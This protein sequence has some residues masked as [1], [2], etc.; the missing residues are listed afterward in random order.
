MRD[1]FRGS[2][3][4]GDERRL[5]DWEDPEELPLTLRGRR[6]KEQVPRGV[7]DGV[8]VPS[9]TLVLEPQLNL[10]LC[11]RERVEVAEIGFGIGADVGLDGAEFPLRNRFPARILYS[12]VLS[13]VR[14]YLWVIASFSV[15][16]TDLEKK[17]GP[18]DCQAILPLLR[19][20]GSSNLYIK[21]ERPW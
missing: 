8:G 21:N 7:V 10:F 12:H 17:N 13:S 3:P 11:E 14:T 1:P 20:A 2:V 9:H 5:R 16:Y 4:L 15:L 19:W 6:E 18:T